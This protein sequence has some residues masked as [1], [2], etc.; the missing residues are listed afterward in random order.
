M[1]DL[2]GPAVP[3]TTDWLS[4]TIKVSKT[5][6]YSVPLRVTWSVTWSVATVRIRFWHGFGGESWPIL[7][8]PEGPSAS[9]CRGCGGLCELPCADREL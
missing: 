3:L 6:T 5:L 1:G 9:R 2:L 4:K 8:N 7:D